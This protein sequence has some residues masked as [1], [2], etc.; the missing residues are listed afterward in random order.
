[1][2]VGLVDPEPEAALAAQGVQLPER[3]IRL[4][5]RDRFVLDVSERLRKQLDAAARAHG[6]LR[7]QHARELLAVLGFVDDGLNARGLLLVAQLLGLHFGGALGRRGRRQARED[8]DGP[9]DQPDDGGD[10]FREGRDGGDGFAHGYPP[11]LTS[12]VNASSVHLTGRSDRKSSRA[13]SS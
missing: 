13:S 1:L 6:A 10:G 9:A 4:R 3:D 8:A 12:R 7:R 11:I 5:V 2:R